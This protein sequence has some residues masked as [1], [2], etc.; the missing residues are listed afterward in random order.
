MG[1]ILGS[2]ERTRKQVVALRF[3]LSDGRERTYQE[4]GEVLG[5][6]AVRAAELMESVRRILRHPSRAYKLRDVRQDTG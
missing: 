3:G 6:N 4:I 5:L 1:A 2:L